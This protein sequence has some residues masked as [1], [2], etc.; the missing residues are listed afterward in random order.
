MLFS[1]RKMRLRK[2]VAVLET[3][4]EHRER[5]GINEVNRRIDHLAEL[6]AEHDKKLE[7]WGSLVR[8]DNRDNSEFDRIVSKRRGDIRK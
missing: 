1:G 5:Q 7:D 3:R 6:V 2:R 4:M 8:R